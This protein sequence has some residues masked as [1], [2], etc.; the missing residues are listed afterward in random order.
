MKFT[1]LLNSWFA[2][3]QLML[4]TDSET[5]RTNIQTYLYYLEDR[6]EKLLQSEAVAIDDLQQRLNRIERTVE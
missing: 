3:K 4:Q 6:M 1:D 5:E 2:Q